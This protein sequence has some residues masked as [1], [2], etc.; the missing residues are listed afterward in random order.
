VTGGYAGIL[1]NSQFTRLESPAGVVHVRE[2]E[3]NR[4][5]LRYVLAQTSPSDPIL[6]LPYGGGVSFANRPTDLYLTTLWRQG[7]VPEELQALD[8]QRLRDKP[9]PS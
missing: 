7:V 4:E 5:I 9:S 2:G 8:L 3:A 1:S 6:E